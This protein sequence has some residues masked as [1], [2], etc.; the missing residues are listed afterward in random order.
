MGG[1]ISATTGR[2]D[3]TDGLYGSSGSC[4]YNNSPRRSND[5]VWTDLCPPALASRAPHAWANLCNHGFDGRA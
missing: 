2:I 5:A 1:R 3:M 4:H